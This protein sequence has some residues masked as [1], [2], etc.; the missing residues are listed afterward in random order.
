MSLLEIVVLSIALALDAMLVSFSYG[1]MITHRKLFNSLLLALS[2]AFFQ[3]LM[4]I[5]GYFASGVFYSKL[6]MFS[7]WIVFTVFMFLGLKFLKEVFDK[8]EKTKIIC[9]SFL[10]L[11]GLSIATSI[12]ALG[13]GISFKFSSVEPLFSC[14]LIGIITFV[15]SFFGFWSSYFFKKFP[16]KSIEIIGALLLIYLALKAIF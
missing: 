8:E 5:I 4:P 14:L 16:S 13:A 15:L 11:L 12:D 9:I 6:E 2:F 1:L 7:K 3:F 10:C